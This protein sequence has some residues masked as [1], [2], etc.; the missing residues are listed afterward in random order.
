VLDGG[1]LDLAIVTALGEDFAGNVEERPH[2][3]RVCEGGFS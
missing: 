3:V 1:G 2:V